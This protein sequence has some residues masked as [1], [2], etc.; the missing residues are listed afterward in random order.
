VIRIPLAGNNFFS[1]D[2]LG[3]V[4]WRWVDARKDGQLYTS[5]KMDRAELAD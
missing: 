3:R 4:N 1:H 5:E 2:A